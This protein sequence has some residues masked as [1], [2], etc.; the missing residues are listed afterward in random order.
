MGLLKDKRVMVSLSNHPCRLTL[1]LNCTIYAFFGYN[2]FMEAIVET[3]GIKPVLAPP[4][5]PLVK[6]IPPKP[7]HLL[8]RSILVHGFSGNID[9]NN[10]WS[11]E[12]KSL[13]K[14]L[15]TGELVSPSK[16][17][18][19][20]KEK[21]RFGIDA[22][23]DK[24]RVIFHVW[25]G[26]DHDGMEYISEALFAAPP[27]MLEGY[28]PSEDPAWPGRAVSA[29]GKDG[30]HIPL[31]NGLLFV[32]AGRCIEFHDHFEALAQKS[33]MSFADFMNKHVVILPN[34]AFQ[35]RNELWT[36]ISSR[37]EPA[38]G[39]TVDVIGAREQMNSTHGTNFTDI[40]NNHAPAKA[41][42]LGLSGINRGS[43]VNHEL[44]VWL[45]KEWRS[46]I[47]WLQT[48]EKNMSNNPFRIEQLREE[49]PSFQDVQQLVDEVQP[50]HPDNKKTQSLARQ[51]YEYRQRLLATNERILEEKYPNAP[52]EID[53]NGRTHSNVVETT[54]LR[55]KDGRLHVHEPL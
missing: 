35:N 37:I 52:S 3:T 19:D 54:V 26:D 7:D 40:L 33:G 47:R 10:T 18:L 21:V 8:E 53:E 46:R 39:V 17:D 9:T 6:E 49:K 5:T 25:K 43:A 15:S 31:S 20:D 42:E 34:T 12:T 28:V 23:F 13:G 36:A 51:Y 44:T 1:A 16:R 30:V 29:Y 41:N 4:P 24:N 38:I 48:T 45:S 22:P 14:V 27:K 32:S 11:E 55:G 50:N 2:A